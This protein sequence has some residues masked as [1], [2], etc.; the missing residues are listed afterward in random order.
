MKLEVRD[1]NGATS[2]HVFVASRGLQHFRVGRDQQCE[3]RV[4]QGSVSRE[5][6]FFFYERGGWRLYDGGQ[7][8]RGSANGTWLSLTDHRLSRY[9]Q[10]SEL[11]ELEQGTE[12]KVSDTILRVDWY[13]GKKV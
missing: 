13:E 9:R 5:Q 10:E 7:G 12:V 11:R 1:K 8:S 4:T 6:C 3:I 2:V